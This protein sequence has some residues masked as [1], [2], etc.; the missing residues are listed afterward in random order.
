MS[1]RYTD[2]CLMGTFFYGLLCMNI[3]ENPSKTTKCD[4]CIK[5]NKILVV[6]KQLSHL[7][8]V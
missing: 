6:I 4:N 8:F 7:I 2:Q 3:T 1:M 5:N